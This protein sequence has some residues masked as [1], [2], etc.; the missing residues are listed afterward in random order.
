MTVRDTG[1]G[2]A[3]ADQAR[4]FEEFAQAR[5]ATTRELEGTGVGLTLSKKFIELHGGTIWVE[6]ARRGQNLRI[7]DSSWDAGASRAELMAWAP[8]FG[9]SAE[10][11]SNAQLPYTQTSHWWS[12]S[13]GLRKREQCIR[14][15]APD[16]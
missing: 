1:I 8:V 6:S 9:L 7:H 10:R 2:I 14:V 11:S 5:S 13:V 3:P 4:V 16:R 15:G 12:M